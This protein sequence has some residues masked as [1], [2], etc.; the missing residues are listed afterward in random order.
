MK[1]KDSQQ[2]PEIHS[3]DDTDFF[4]L[5]DPPPTHCTE[6]Q[7]IC[8]LLKSSRALG[9]PLPKITSAARLQRLQI[10]EVTLRIF[11]HC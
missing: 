4:V 5:F 3:P 10:R 7:S 9:S 6:E 2:G 11:Q 8:S 1:P